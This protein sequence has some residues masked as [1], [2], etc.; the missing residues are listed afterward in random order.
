VAADGTQLDCLDAD[1]AEALARLDPRA[2]RKLAAALASSEALGGDEALARRLVVSV[3]ALLRAAPADS[4]ICVYC[5][6]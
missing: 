5:T 2:A 1:A 3:Q 4:R 6:L